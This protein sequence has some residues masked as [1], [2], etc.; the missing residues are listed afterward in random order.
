MERLTKEMEVLKLES[1]NKQRGEAEVRILFCVLVMSNSNLT[2]FLAASPSS[3]FSAS[4]A[5]LC[6]DVC[7]CGTAVECTLPTA[8][9]RR[10]TTDLTTTRIITSHVAFRGAS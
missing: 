7:E 8:V 9:T 10:S 1:T 6:G 4:A 3:S 2:S 5:D